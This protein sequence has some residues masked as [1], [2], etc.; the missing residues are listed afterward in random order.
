MAG[1]R[2]LHVITRFIIG[3]AQ[4]NTLLS[5]IG[6][7]RL[8]RWRVYLATGPALG[9]EGS[10]LERARAEGIQPIILRHMQRELHPVRDAAAYLELERVMRR[11]RPH[12]VHTH[13]SKA[14]ILGRMAAF[15]CGV[16]VIV[17]TVHGPSFHAYERPWRNRLF[18]FLERWAARRT[19]ALVAV[20]D[21]M[22]RQY[23]ERG[24][25][26]PRQYVTIRSGIEI[27]EYVEPPLSKAAARRQL[28]MPA[29]AFVF[30]KVARLAPLK[31][32]EDVMRAAAQVLPAVPALHLLFIGDGVLADELKRQ[33]ERLG[34]AK[35]ITFTGLVPP[36]DV[37]GLLAAADALVHA[38][39]RE[40]LPRA[41]VQA[42]LSGLPAAAY[43]VDG[44]PE[45]I[46]DS[47]TGWLVP[48]GDWQAL[49]AKMQGLAL[50]PEQ[51]RRMGQAARRK[52]TSEFDWRKMVLRLDALYC[53][54]LLSKR[55]RVHTL[56][57]GP[58]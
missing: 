33:A 36:A 27:D 28:G 44:A 51:A 40:G 58:P 1:S 7:R 37:P 12:I 26:T 17:H 34:M 20:A 32:H 23:L 47:E 21:A 14:G 11:I 29:D 53:N 48:A 24:I 43:A 25:G 2:V 22:T 15:H 18:V 9:P 31:G 46:A 42:G 3:G 52:L 30:A 56:D 41:V 16:P 57:T 50:A 10:L 39:Y 19:S 4:E 55:L 5:V 54:L 38:S 49:A 8:R 45:A 35:R 13:S 6:L